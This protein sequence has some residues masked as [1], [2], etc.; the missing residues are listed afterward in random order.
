M[1]DREQL[2]EELATSFADDAIRDIEFLSIA[3]DDCVA[4]YI[5]YGQLLEGDETEVLG[6]AT[7]RRSFN[8]KT[9]VI[10]SKKRHAQLLDAEADAEHAALTA[11]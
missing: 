8:P 9:H 4:D 10:V 11:K 7:R 6:R 3:E 2:L 5:D 1:S